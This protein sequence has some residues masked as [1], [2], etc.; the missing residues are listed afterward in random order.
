MQKSIKTKKRP[1]LSDQGLGWLAGWL[2]SRRDGKRKSKN[3][4]L[5][6]WRLRPRT[7][8]T[9]ADNPSTNLSKVP[10][11]LGPLRASQARVRPPIRGSGVQSESLYFV[12]QRHLLPAT[13]HQI[14]CA[15][16]IREDGAQRQCL[17]VS[18]C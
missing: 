3:R 5:L 6:A 18:L 16:V 7:G 14:T 10:C 11:L 9:A 4:N 2:A 13:G 15:P 17:Q 8:R 1:W 12:S